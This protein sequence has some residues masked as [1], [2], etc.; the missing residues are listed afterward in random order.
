MY[1]N[2]K[3]GGLGVGADARVILVVAVR[4]EV[5]IVLATH[6]VIGNLRLNFQRPN[7]ML[8]QRFFMVL[9]VYIICIAKTSFLNTKHASSVC[10]SGRSF[11]A[12]ADT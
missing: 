10:P 12:W 2:L 4:V 3:I 8:S 5:R 1:S 7:Y 9:F 6:P 11:L